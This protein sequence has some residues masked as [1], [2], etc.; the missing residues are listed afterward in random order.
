MQAAL[1][2]DSRALRGVVFDRYERLK[3]AGELDCQDPGL[4]L[5]FSPDSAP[6]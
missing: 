1:S 5:H 2:L 6:V 4:N 3:R